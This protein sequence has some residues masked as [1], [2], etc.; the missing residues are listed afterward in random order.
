[1]EKVEV[2]EEFAE[3][4]VIDAGIAV[5]IRQGEN[6]PDGEEEVGVVGVVQVVLL[7]I[8]REPGE[9]VARGKEP[10]PPAR[11]ETDDPGFRGEPMQRL[12][13]FSPDAWIESVGEGDSGSGISCRGAPER[14][15]AVDQGIAQ[16]AQGDTETGS[17]SIPS[18]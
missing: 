17:V 2:V 5:R 4:L 10:G 8:S 15:T 14:A 18:C 12:C 6:R 13:Q 11:H 1:M 3:D 9:R 16:F 7:L